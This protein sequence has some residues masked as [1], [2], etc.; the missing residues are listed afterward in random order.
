MGGPGSGRKPTPTEWRLI[1]STPAGARRVRC[2]ET[3]AAPADEP[4]IPEWLDGFLKTKWDRVTSTMREMGTLSVA[5]QD[6]LELYVETWDK[7]RKSK[8]VVDKLGACYPVEDGKGRKVLKANPADVTM[9]AAAKELVRMQAELG[10]T[11]SGKARL[12]TRKRDAVSA[13]VRRAGG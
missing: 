12:F 13:R 4:T 7:Y 9:R 8:A 10:L 3:P 5:Y 6:L 2:E 11:P 1:T